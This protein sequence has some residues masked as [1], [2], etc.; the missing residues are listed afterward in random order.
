ALR[1]RQSERRI[2][3]NDVGQC[4]QDHPHHEAHVEVEEGTE[5]RWEVS[6]AAELTKVHGSGSFSGGNW[7]WRQVSNLPSRIGKLGNL[8]PHW[9]GGH[10]LHV[11]GAELQL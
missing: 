5:Q 3:D 11:D 6:G 9:I 7:L 1:R 2:R 4:P 8:P 10:F